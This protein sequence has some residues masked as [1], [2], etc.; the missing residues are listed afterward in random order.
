MK[1]KVAM[2][3]LHKLLRPAM[4]LCL[5]AAQYL[6]NILGN[7]NS[8][9][10]SNPY[11]VWFGV[12]LIVAGVLL[13][14]RASVHCQRS[15]SAEK[16]AKSGPYKYIRHPIYVSMYLLCIGL[17]F[18]FFTW[19]HFLVLALFIPLWWI[20]SKSEENEM[21]WEYGEEYITY[22]E[23]TCMIIPGIL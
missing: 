23:R 4:A 17:G 6:S 18:V 9:F 1:E 12:I 11:L 21:R 19:L 13:L 14:W 16:L 8:V 2:K 5:A 15:V 10:S 3:V 22:Q 7:R 20:E